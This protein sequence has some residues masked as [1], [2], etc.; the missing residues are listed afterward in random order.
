MDPYGISVFLRPTKQGIGLGI[1]VWG[2][3][4]DFWHLFSYYL[5]K[6][7]CLCVLGSIP[8]KLNQDS[9]NRSSESVR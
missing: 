2:Q 5:K 8:S 7:T 3:G 9:L 1:L 6:K 4:C